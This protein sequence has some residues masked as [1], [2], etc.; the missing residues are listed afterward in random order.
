MR[1]LATRFSRKLVGLLPEGIYA[2]ANAPTGGLPALEEAALGWLLSSYSFDATES[3]WGNFRNS[4]CPRASTPRACAASPPLSPWAA[5]ST[6]LPMTWGRTLGS[7]ALRVAKRYK[8]KAAVV[9]GEALLKDNF[10]LIH[11]AR[12][13]RRNAGP[14]SRRYQLGPG[15]GAEGDA[16]GKGVC[17][18]TG[19]S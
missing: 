2:F 10:P 18:D 17:F 6:R 8:A 15:Q 11:A 16:V 4:K 19:G 1:R 7:R 3:R 5:I 13:R 14:A 12:N 9:R